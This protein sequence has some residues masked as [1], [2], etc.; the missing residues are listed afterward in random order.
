M[1]RATKLKLQQLL[2]IV[3]AWVVIGFLITVYDHLIINS[4]NSAGTSNQYSFMTSLVINLGAGLI[5]SLLGGSI[6]VFFVNV[7]YQDKP[8]GYTILIVS[9]C[10]ILI[11]ALIFPPV[12]EF[13]EMAARDLRYLWWLILLLALAVWLIWGLGKKKK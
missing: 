9:I 13:F 8:Y 7:K 10:F 1:N 12:L 4:H 11:L 3:I 6:L 5:G 2:V